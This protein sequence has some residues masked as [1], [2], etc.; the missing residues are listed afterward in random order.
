MAKGYYKYFNRDISWLSYD[1]LVLESAEADDVSVGEALNFISFHS[2]NLDEFYAVRVAEYR[3]SASRDI[4]M[5]EVSNPSAMLHHINAIVSRQMLEAADIVSRT[6][7]PKLLEQGVML[8][9]D[10]MPTDETHVAFMRNYFEREVIPYVQPV[11][12]GKGTL[13]F[14]R[15]NMPYFAVRLFAKKRH[16]K[17]SNKADY[18]LV[19]LPTSGVPRF[20]TLPDNGDGLTHIVFIDDIIRMNLPTLFPGYSVDGAWGIKISRDADLAISETLGCDI[21][22]EIRD[23]LVLRKTGAPAGFYHDSTMPHDV[24]KCLKDNFN[25]AE[26][27]MAVCGS[28][29]NLQ[30]LSHLPVDRGQ[31]LKAFGLVV[32]RRLIVCASMLDDITRGDFM[33]HYPYQSFNY[34]IRLINEAAQDPY[35]TEIKVTQY[36]VAT[37]S[38]VVNSLI[39]AAA[40]NKRVTV[41]VELKA[42][43][44][45]KNNLEMAD[46]M[47]A[48]GIKIIYSIPGL[49]VHAKVALIERGGDSGKRSVAYVS[50]GNFNEQTAK[51][52]TDHGLFTADPDIISDLR[53]VF[54]FLETHQG[55]AIPKDEPIPTLKKLLVS[56]LNMEDELHKLIA[57]ETDIASHGGEGRIMLKMNGIQYRPL[58]NDLYEASLAGVKIEIMA[59]GIC[60]IVPNQSYSQNI[61]LTRLVD[62]YLEHGRVWTFGPDG[63]RGVYITSSDWLNR[64]MRNRIEVAAPIIN[65]ALRQELMQIMNLLMSDNTRAKIIDENQQ[66]VAVP[67]KQGEKS[68]RAQQD[69]Y[70]LISSWQTSTDENATYG[71]SKGN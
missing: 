18:S 61:R 21:A 44:D 6:L 5:D 17:L 63:E 23:N 53:I 67:H 2:S 58:I 38:A 37:N 60:C 8:H 54:N 10:N 40:A 7:V 26:S 41:F 1:R 57:R 15:D 27:E 66:N 14:L 11:L 46:R 59:R 43:F 51:T 36:R 33:L 39:A 20:V 62:D 19:K 25:F 32:P 16:G 12:L 71:F 65:A 31:N 69:M 49:K 68:I 28:Y 64:N 34:V 45:E 48:A 4:R 24:L 13:V 3:R 70:H 47:K 56:R 22:E 35:V 29:L 52:Y 9:F 42:R 55:K 30:D 50:T